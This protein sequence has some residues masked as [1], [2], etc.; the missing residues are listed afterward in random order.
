MPWAI[1][2]EAGEK[3]VRSDALAPKGVVQFIKS[4]HISGDK[5]GGT[6]LGN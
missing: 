1:S 6:F 5:G 3:L 2:R 4:I